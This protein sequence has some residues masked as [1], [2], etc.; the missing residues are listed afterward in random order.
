MW[1]PPFALDISKVIKA[2][3]NELEI[4]VTNT[5]VNRLIG[6]EALPDTSGYKMTGKTVPWLNANEPPPKS[7]RVT[8]TGFNFFTKEK[9]KILQ[10][11]G[12]IGPVRIIEP[13]Q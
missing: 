7:E 13:E 6:D 5:W 11:S 4:K 1:K 10:T 3:N 9:S 8:F 2:G 12:L